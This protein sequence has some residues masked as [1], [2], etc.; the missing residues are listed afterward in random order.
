MNGMSLAWCSLIVFCFRRKNEEIFIGAN[1]IVL[2][3]RQ[4][5]LAY[6]ISWS[7]QKKARLPTECIRWL[8]ILLPFAYSRQRWDFISPNYTSMERA[9][10]TQFHSLSS[11]YLFFSLILDFY[12]RKKINWAMNWS[13]FDFFKM[14]LNHWEVCSLKEISF[15]VKL[16]WNYK[17]A[18]NNH[19]FRWA[20][21]CKRTLSWIFSIPYILEH[22]TV[23]H[24]Y[25]KFESSIQHFHWNRFSI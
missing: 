12:F 22:W 4:L 24:R 11:F 10:H 9:V 8:Y 18:N 13:L 1:A 17:S 5:L 2:T 23:H 20:N 21:S 3:A 25:T 7:V 19:L 6:K 15:N 14:G 16:W